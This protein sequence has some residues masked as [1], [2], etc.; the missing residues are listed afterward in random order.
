MLLLVGCQTQVKE[1]YSAKDKQCLRKMESAMRSVD[2]FLYH[3]MLPVDVKKQWFDVKY[4]CWK[5]G[6]VE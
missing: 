4:E 6:P 2:P 1:V 3:G 5:E